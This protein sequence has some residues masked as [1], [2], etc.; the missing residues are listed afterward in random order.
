MA[1]MKVKIDR[2]FVIFIA[3]MVSAT[4][5]VGQAKVEGGWEV[6]LTTA[7]GPLEFEMYVEQQGS[8]LSGHLSSP[9]GESPLTGS[10]DGSQIKLNWT[11]PDGDQ[12]LEIVFTGTISGDEI[13][14]TAKLGR[15]GYG[16]MIARRSD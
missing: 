9:G 13:K 16:S 1:R 2:A 3:V 15:R 8:Q 12:V 7:G 4:L 11:L 5:L 10:V 14:G 6:I